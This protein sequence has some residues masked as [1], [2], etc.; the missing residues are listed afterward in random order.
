MQLFEQLRLQRKQR[1][2]WFERKQRL[3]RKQR[4]LRRP[5]LPRQR[6]E[7]LVPGSNLVREVRQH[8]EP[9]SVRLLASCV[10]HS[11]LERLERQHLEQQLLRDQWRCIRLQRVGRRARVRDEGRR[12]RLYVAIDRLSAVT[13]ASVFHVEAADPSEASRYWF[14]ALAVV[15]TSSALCSGS[16]SVAM[17]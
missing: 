2:Q 11:G 17:V 12:L 16:M 4:N 10:L 5:L 8:L 1:F 14:A 13:D 15:A 6:H 7:L 3:E 9:G